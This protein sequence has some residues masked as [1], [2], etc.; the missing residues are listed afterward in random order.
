[1]CVPIASSDGRLAV[2]EARLFWNAMDAWRLA[3][4]NPPAKLRGKKLRHRQSAPTFAIA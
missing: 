1:M 2:G 3:P 4:I